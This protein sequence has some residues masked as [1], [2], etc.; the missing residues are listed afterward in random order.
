MSKTHRSFLKTAG[1]ISAAAAGGVNV[2]SAAPEDRA[3]KQSPAPARKEMHCVV[4]GQIKSGKSVIVSQASMQPITV[5]MIPGVELYRL[6]GS[7]AL[8]QL[9]SAGTSRRPE[10]AP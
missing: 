6:W 7:D 4:T 1:M 9:P 5:G 2:A 10:T 8:V 3:R